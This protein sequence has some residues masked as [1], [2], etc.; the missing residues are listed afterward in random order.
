M[1]LLETTVKECLNNIVKQ[2]ASQ[3]AL[4]ESQSKKTLSWQQ[5]QQEVENVA[6]GFLAIGLKKVIV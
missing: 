3:I 4:I 5:L 2:Y 6:R 1:T